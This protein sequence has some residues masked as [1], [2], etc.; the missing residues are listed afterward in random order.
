MGGR[1]ESLVEERLQPYLVSQSELNTS[2]TSSD[3][4]A[5]RGNLQEWLRGEELNPREAIKD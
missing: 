1:V 4:L 5:G 2:K 3:G